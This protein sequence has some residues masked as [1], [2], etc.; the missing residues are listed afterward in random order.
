MKEKFQLRYTLCLVGGQNQETVEFINKF[1][2]SIFSGHF[3]NGF[4]RGGNLE[5]NTAWRA[6]KKARKLAGID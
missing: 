1:G 3:M 4:F 5:E 6:R 2:D